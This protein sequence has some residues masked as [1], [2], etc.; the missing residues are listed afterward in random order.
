MYWVQ[1]GGIFKLPK[2]STGDVMSTVV[3]TLGA[4]DFVAVD[5]QRVYWTVFESGGAVTAVDKLSAAKSNIAAPQDSPIGLAI[6]PTHAYWALYDGDAIVRAPLDGSAPAGETVADTSAQPFFVA[7]RDED[8]YWTYRGPSDSGGVQVH[9]AGGVTSTLA[10]EHPAPSGLAVD[11][12]DVYWEDADG[13]VHRV[14]RSGGPTNEIAAAEGPIFSGEVRLDDTHVYWAGPGADTCT[15]AP[16][17]C[18]D[19]PCKG[20]VWRAAKPDG[21]PELFATGDWKGVRG[22]AVDDVAVYWTTSDRRL[23]RKAKAAP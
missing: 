7:L 15:T 3:V 11:A 1:D 18:I 23:M 16:C 12:T 20:N 21:A 6:S 19:A 14:A 5:D 2:T 13:S 4:P 22:L 10:S 8:T 9:G 17:V